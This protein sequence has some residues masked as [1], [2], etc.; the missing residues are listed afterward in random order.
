LTGFQAALNLI[1]GKLQIAFNPRVQPL[2]AALFTNGL[3]LFRGAEAVKGM[4]YIHQLLSI[5]LVDVLPLT[6]TVRTM[7][8]THVR[9]FIPFQPQPAQRF[10]DIFFRLTSTPYLI[11]IF[12]PQN[13]LA[14]MLARE[15]Q[16]EQSN[17]G[18]TNV[19]IPGGRR[20]D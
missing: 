17:I 14:A 7:G 9:A 5:L 15:A 18:S 1:G 6:L 12:N 2:G 13:K 16:I 10:Q 8:T 3:Q 19:R 11:G 20:R 4:A